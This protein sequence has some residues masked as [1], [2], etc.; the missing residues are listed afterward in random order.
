[1]TRL[2]SLVRALH[3][4]A[5]RTAL[6]AVTLL[7]LLEGSTDQLRSLTFPHG[8]HGKGEQGG[9]RDKITT[10]RSRCCQLQTTLAGGGHAPSSCMLGILGTIA[11]V[12]RQ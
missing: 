3:N 11:C 7:A 6:V 2:V 5:A 8:A 1:M 9:R 4:F 10:W 12:M